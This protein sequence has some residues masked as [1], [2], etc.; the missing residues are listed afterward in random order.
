MGSTS[1]WAQVNGWRGDTD[2]LEKKRKGVEFDL[3]Y[4]NH[5]SLDRRINI[6]IIV[7]TVSKGFISEN[8]Y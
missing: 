4:M 6:K 8:A 2:T 5:W 7:Q 1:G 3:F